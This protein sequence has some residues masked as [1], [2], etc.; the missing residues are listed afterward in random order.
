[1]TFSIAAT[2]PLRGEFGV[3][4]TSSSICVASRC[5]FVRRGTGAALTQNITD[6]TLGPRLL[7]L[8]ASGLTADDALQQIINNQPHVE[9]RQLAIVDQ[10]SQVAAYT[11]SEALGISAQATGQQSVAIGNLLDNEQVVQTMVDHFEKITANNPEQP[12]AKRLLEAMDA[13]A[14]AGG[15]AGPVQSAGLLLVSDADWPT[16]DLRVDWHETPLQELDALWQR[17][18]PQLD[19]Y[20]TRARDP[21]IAPSYGVPGDP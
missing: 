12:L 13:G 15:E 5:A 17:Y 14:N 10:S 3:A 21:R 20:K 4:V 2:C 11:G 19:D 1:M 8:C 6:P 9:F 18:Q 7:D 16:V